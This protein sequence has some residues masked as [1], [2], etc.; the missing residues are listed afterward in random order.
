MID[1]IPAG[2]AGCCRPDSPFPRAVLAGLTVLVCL[3]PTVASAAQRQYVIREPIYQLLE[4]TE[5]FRGLCRRPGPAN[6]HLVLFMPSAVRTV[7]VYWHPKAD[8]FIQYPGT[9]G[10]V[11]WKRRVTTA[12]G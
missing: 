1:R 8:R 3:L 2:R 4:M 7:P 9:S 12:G 10:C 11:I 5:D 6:N